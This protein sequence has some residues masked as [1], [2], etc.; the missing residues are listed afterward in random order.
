MGEM[1]R[2]GMVALLIEERNDRHI[3]ITDDGAG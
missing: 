2:A 1:E 3:H